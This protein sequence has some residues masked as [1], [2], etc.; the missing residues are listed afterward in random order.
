MNTLVR[1]SAL[2]ALGFGLLAGSTGCELQQCD[3]TTTND[4]GVT[5]TQKG[6]CAKS[7]EK[8]V[9]TAETKQA[10]W[11][12]GSEVIIDG[13]NGP[14]TVVKGSGTLV[15]AT[16]TPVDL[17]AHGTSDAEIQADFAALKKDVVGDYN[18]TGNVLVKSY[19]QGAAHTG[20]GAELRVELPAS[21]DGPL[22]IVQHNGETDAQY[23][24]S[25]SSISVSSDN[26]GVTGAVGRWQRVRRAAPS[27]RRTARLP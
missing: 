6:V 25:A 9:G 16:F 4:A 21:F 3:V 27:P 11:T 1:T 22:T 20:L 17:R 23:V 26:G 5:T 8:W 19:Q 15:T 10:Q 13:F 12:P 24:G 2:F 7:L 14:I 18:G